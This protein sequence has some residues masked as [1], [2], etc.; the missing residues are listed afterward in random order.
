MLDIIRGIAQAA[1]NLKA[2]NGA[3]HNGRT[4]ERES[5]NINDSRVRDGFYVKFGDNLLTLGYQSDIELKELHEAGKFEDEME[6]VMKDVVSFLKKEYRSVTGKSLTL[7]SEGDVDVMVQSTSNV[8][9]FVNV[10]KLYKIGG[11][12]SSAPEERTIDAKFQ[13][14]LE[15]GGWT[16]A[17]DNGND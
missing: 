3:S 5:Y 12:E 11:I 9:S 17:S 6:S 7:S 15:Q 10:S 4:L 2:V 14:F 13:K 16:G 1:A 8:R